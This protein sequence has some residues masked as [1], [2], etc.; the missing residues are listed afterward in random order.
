MNDEVGDGRTAGRLF[1]EARILCGSSQR[2]RVLE[3]LY[4]EQCGTTLFGGSRLSIPDGGGWELLSSDPD[5]EGIPDRQVDRFVDRRS[6]SEYGV[7]WPVGSSSLN[8]DA[9]SWQQP[10]T[11]DRREPATWSI[12][13]LDPATGRVRLGPPN[14]NGAWISGYMFVANTS[15]PGRVRALP[16]ACPRCAE[17]YNKKQFRRSPI[18]GFRTGFSKLTQLLSKELFYFIPSGESRKLVVFSDSRKEAAGL[19]NGIE[20]SHYPDLIRQVMYE[21]LSSAAIEEPTAATEIREFGDVRSAPA[22]RFAGKTPGGMV[23]L[24]ELIA[25]ATAEIPILPDSGMVAALERRRADASRELDR[26]VHVK[27]TRTVPLRGLF[28]SL[29]PSTPEEPGAVIGRLKSIGVNPSGNDVLYQSYK[30][31]RRYHRWIELF[32]FAT[33]ESGWRADLSPEA[34]ERRT[35]LRAKVMSEICDVLFGRLYLGFESAGLGYATLDLDTTTYE[36]TGNGAGISPDVLSSICSATVRVLGDLYRYPRE[37]SPYPLREWPRWEDARAKLRNF[38]HDCA[39]NHGLGECAVLDAVRRAVCETGGHANLVIDP[40]RIAI[41]VAT[42]NDPVWT[43]Q[44]CRRSHL[45]NPGA[46]TNCRKALASDP[47][48]VCA[49]LH[50]RNYYAKEAIAHREP[51][52]LH[53]EELTAQTDDQAERQ[54]LFRS[55]VVQLPDQAEPL[56]PLVDEIDVLSVTTTME[57][58]VDIGNLQA[59]ALANMPPMRFNYQQRAGR[60]GRRGQA[61]AVVL[62]LCRGRSHDE[63]YYRHPEQITRSRPPVPF[64]SMGRVEIAERLMAKEVLHGAFQHAGVQW[65]DGPVPPDT[66]GEFGLGAAWAADPT[67][68]AA[69]NAYI[70]N[71]ED[72]SAIATDLLRGVGP[73]IDPSQ[74]VTFAR[75]SLPQKIAAVVAN[76]ELTGDGLAERLAEGGVLPMFGMPSR[77]R[78]LYHR[79]AGERAYTIDRDLDLAVTEFAPGSEITKDKRIHRAV[80]F[81]SALLFRNG[82][83]TP[84]TQDP[85]PGRRWMARCENCHSTETSATPFNRDICAQCGQGET[86]YPPFRRFEFVVPLAFRTSFGPGEDAKEENDQVVSGSASAAES[87][88]SPSEIVPS[89]NTRLGFSTAGRVY[90]INDRR[91]DLFAGGLGSTTRGNLWHDSQWID[92]RF[93]AADQVAFTSSGPPERIALAAPKTTDVLRIQPASSERGL[94]LDPSRSSGAVK[95][96]YYSA[97]FILRSTAAQLLDIDPDEI[98]VSDVRQVPLHDGS[99]G[100]EIVLSDHLPNGAGFVSWIHEEWPSLLSRM[101]S[102]SEPRGSFIGELTSDQHRIECDSSGYDCLRQY[103][104]MVYHGLL[105]W[106]LGLTLIRCL[107]KST[108]TCGLDGEFATPDL[109]GWTVFAEQLRGSFCG[110]FGCTPRDFGPLPGFTVGIKQVILTHPLWDTTTPTG[111]LAEAQATCG[112]DAVRHMDTFNLLRRPSWAYQRLG[113]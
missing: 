77:S 60:A 81:T 87:D 59:V 19:A 111:L 69:V 70:Q 42:P 35:K 27:N 72:V 18:R 66:H 105:D 45:H 49:D 108:F 31:D 85:I 97:A 102:V 22:I 16:A 84:A 15:D 3:M 43:C 61:F 58:G 53:T 14:G 73:R 55:I 83:F 89:T 32:D 88:S 52:R 80:G 106:R 67:R 38:V 9:E 33:P 8:P 1:T 90:R 57:V 71:S 100:G 110:A 36:R 47:D 48:A 44:S 13:Q 96:A 50:D 95:A 56:E 78:L 10:R 64:L 107:G 65:W 63:F 79:I 2:H 94:S 109:Q 17:D 37:P 28:E 39:R 98:D 34:S 82:A 12:A 6:Y 5:I 4:C 76:S 74:L 23:A 68:Q 86:D 29:D 7:F 40:R 51:I 25:T 91:G 30:F 113:R 99:V 46:C 21:A 20:R 112:P 104:N 92:E 101:T 75:G 24:K 26:L 103:R 54:R 93:Q 11:D 41:R 62:T